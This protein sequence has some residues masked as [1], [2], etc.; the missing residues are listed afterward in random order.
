MSNLNLEA[1]DN[2]IDYIKESEMELRKLASELDTLDNLDK[3]AN[4]PV[5]YLDS[6]QVLNFLKAY[7]G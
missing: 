1:L 4:A 5:E 2:I 7:M 3:Y 6:T